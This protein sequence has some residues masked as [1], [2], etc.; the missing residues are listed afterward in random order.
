[1]PPSPGLGAGRNRG[2]RPDR[3]RSVMTEAPT[4]TTARA[5]RDRQITYREDVMTQQPPFF[6][7]PATGRQYTVD[8]KTGQSVWVDQHVPTHATPG[9]SRGTRPVLVV[10]AVLGLGFAALVAVGAALSAGKSS[11]SGTSGAAASTSTSPTCLQINGNCVDTNVPTVQPD[12]PSAPADT[13]TAQAGT[14]SQLNALRAAQNYL[15]MKGFSRA[16][17]IAQLSSAYGDQFSV[18]DATWAAD[19]VGADWNEQAV[20]AGQSYLDMKGFSRA[21]LIEQL[22]SP[23]GDQFTRKQATYAADKLGLK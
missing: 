9:A 20:R 6:T 16:G 14:L 23:Y 17:L 21:G 8:P 5:Y 2:G 7:D 22:S 10:L 19:H 13:P 18:A 11:G 3:V 12:T 15:G 4:A 1:M